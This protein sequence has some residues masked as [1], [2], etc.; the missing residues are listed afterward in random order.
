[1][2]IIGIPKEIKNHEHRVGM[3]PDGVREL[4]LHGHQVMVERGCGRGAG[5][6]DDDYHKAGADIVDVSAVFEHANLIVKVKEPQPEECRLLNP[7]QTLFTYLH[8]AAD[9][10]QAK[11]LMQSGACCIAYETVTDQNNGLPL[12]APM[13]EVAGRMSVQEGAHYL[14]NGQ[15]GSGVLLA[16]VPGVQPGKVLVIGGGVVGNSAA[17]M[18][19][20]LGAEVTI[21]DRSLPRLRWLDELYVGRVKTIYSTTSAI[22]TLASES[23][24]VIG[25]VLIPGATAPKLLSRDTL[26]KMRPGSVVV[27]VAIDQGGCFETSKPTTHA[28]P[29]FV[30]EGVIHYCVTNMPGAVARTST[31]ALTTATLPHIL[32]LADK[33]SWQAMRDDKHL[34]RGLNVC[35]GFITNQSVANSLKLDFSEPELVLPMNSAESKSAASTTST[36]L[37]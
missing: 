4:I 13:S 21:V 17:R 24:L 15:G 29:T 14:E 20:G 2:T 5:F 22:E 18:A 31:M 34:M 3:T 7:D 8:L 25:A 23:D 27:D 26:K 16:G 32:A 33:G 10:T 37:V 9:A 36:Y 35:N 19:V 6:N 12:L 11:L 30:E 28:V 1:M